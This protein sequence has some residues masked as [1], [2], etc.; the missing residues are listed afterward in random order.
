MKIKVKPEGREEVYIPEKESLKE[1]IK[2]KNFEQIHNF[3]PSGPLIIGA[4][5]DIDSV[6]M[7]IDEAERLAVLTGSS[8]LANLEH[9]LSLI[10]N[11]R[12]ELYDIGDVSEKDLEI[13]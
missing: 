8:K 12:L 6:L 5:H 4:D 3:V 9:G 11:N 2:S 7:D 1:W 13:I 10:I